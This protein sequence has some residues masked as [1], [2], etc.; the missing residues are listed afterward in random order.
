[1]P[2]WW[3]NERWPR[4]LGSEGVPL[5]VGRAR[6]LERAEPEDRAPPTDCIGIDVNRAARIAA[7]GHGRQV[8]IS[9]AARGFVEYELPSRQRIQSRG[10]L[11]FEETLR[12]K[13]RSVNAE[14]PAG[15]SGYASVV[16]SRLSSRQWAL[17]FFLVLAVLFAPA[18]EE[19]PASPA[20]LA[21]E[22]VG[23][24]ILAPTFS[25]GITA[26]GP[27][28]SARQLPGPDQRSRPASISVTLASFA[29]VLLLLASLTWLARQESRNV[30]RLFALRTRVPRAPP[31]LLAA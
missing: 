12:A 11:P 19:G 23:A 21:D 31:T 13:S 14:M 18:R 4:P 16:T 1:M 30:L 2:Q 24:R 25:E 3:P 8:L 28:L 20:R 7:T 6:T 9:D 15:D 17:A 26:T 5:R 10:L 27:K 29:A 22:S